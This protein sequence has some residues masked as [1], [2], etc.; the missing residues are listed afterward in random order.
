MNIIENLQYAIV[1]KFSFGWPKLDD[2]RIQISKQCNIKGECKIGLLRNRHIL[3]RLSHMEDFVN[4]LSK[5]VYYILAKDGFSYQMRPFIYDAK[6]KP[7][8]ETSKAVAWI[9]FPDLLSTFFGKE[10]LFSIASAIG[11]PLQLGMVMINKTRP[12]CTR[13]KILVDLLANLPEVIEIEV[14]N[15]KQNEPS[16]QIVKIQYDFVPKYC[17]TCKL[18]GHDEEECRTLYPELKKAYHN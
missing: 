3:F 17:K 7:T 10:S 5:S 2:L 16:I 1:G 18:Q 8:V 15:N 11:K 6:F 12:S 13:V 4:I 9:S 14:V